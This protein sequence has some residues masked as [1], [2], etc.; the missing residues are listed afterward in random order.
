MLFEPYVGCACP[1]AR[2]GGGAGSETLVQQAIIGKAHAR[3]GKEPWC[4]EGLRGCRVD[5]DPG[6]VVLSMMYTFRCLEGSDDGGVQ[7]S[8]G[9]VYIVCREF[10]FCGTSVTRWW[11]ELIM[12]E[13]SLC[14]SGQ[15]L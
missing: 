7:T 5:Q 4:V 9:M 8:R 10:E 15:S 12:H 13:Q 14:Y 3:Q 11:A 2:G 6:A 1:W